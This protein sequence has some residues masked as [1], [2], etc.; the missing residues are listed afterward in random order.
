MTEGERVLAAL[1]GCFA[2][3]CSVLEGARF[4]DRAG[5]DLV[6]YPPLPLPIG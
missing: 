1:A 6:S 5:Y 2:V 4:E 3:L